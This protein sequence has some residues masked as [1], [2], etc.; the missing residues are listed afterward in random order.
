MVTNVTSFGRSGLSDFVIQRVSAVI[1][2]LYVLCIVGFFLANPSVNFEALSRF[3]AS[4]PMKMFSTLAD[5]NVNIDM[6]STSPIRISCVI[7]AEQVGE[8]VRSLHAAF[9]LE[10]DEVTA[11]TSPACGGGGK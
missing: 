4:L 3:F 6:I 7:S 8:A 5:A 2:A 11:E 1:I 10:N 9:G